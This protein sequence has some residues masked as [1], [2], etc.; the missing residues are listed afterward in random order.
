MHILFILL[1]GSRRRLH[2]G[3]GRADDRMQVLPSG[4]QDLPAGSFAAG[5]RQRV[6]DVHETLQEDLS[7]R[8]RSSRFTN[9]RTKAMEKLP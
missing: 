8:V 2:S 4:A 3:V 9:S 5:V 7:E 1:L 6:R